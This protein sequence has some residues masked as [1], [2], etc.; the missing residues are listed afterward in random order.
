MIEPEPL[1]LA[2]GRQSAAAGEI[3]RGARRLLKAH[4]FASLPEV[5]L[6]SGR[7]A[8]LLALGADGLITIVEIKSSVAD[9]RAD[10]KWPDYQDF[11]DR[12][13][14]A[15][16]PGFPQELIPPGVG[17]IVADRYGGEIVREAPSHKVAPARRKAV[18]LLFARV[19]ATRLLM[20][21]D[22]EAFQGERVEI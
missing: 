20:S 6:A 12:L 2:D 9:F 5:T 18:T 10:R 15:V 4:A 19:A 16:G 1:E 17:L 8:D 11:A 7:R 22:P 3:A 14:F 21:A 13:Y